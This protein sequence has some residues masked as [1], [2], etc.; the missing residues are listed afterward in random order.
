MN[1]QKIITFSII[2]TVLVL[3]ISFFIYGNKVSFAPSA[4][5]EIDLKM[6]P[7]ENKDKIQGDKDD[8]VSFSILP[9]TKVKGILSYRGV[10]KGGYFFEGNILINILDLDKKVLKASNGI[11]KSDWMTVEQVDFEGNIDFTNIPKGS[12]YFEIKQDDPSDGESGRPIKNVL[13][14]IFIE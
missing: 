8:L 1:K 4:K 11:A 9:D 14:P 7:I 3:G 5:P 13:I 2:I 12:A 10:I 6:P